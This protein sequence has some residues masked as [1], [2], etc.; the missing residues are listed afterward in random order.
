MSAY[1]PGVFARKCESCGHIQADDKPTSLSP[2]DSYMFRKCKKCKSESLDY[3]HEGY[4]YNEK[5]AIVRIA[6]IDNDE[7]I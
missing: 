2:P 7:E 1:D 6:A 3:G 5:G 4:A